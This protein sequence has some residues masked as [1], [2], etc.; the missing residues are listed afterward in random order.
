MKKALIAL[1][2]VA[3]V[4]GIAAVV[5]TFRPPQRPASLEKVARTPARLA[6]GEYLVRHVLACNECHTARDWSR[7]GGPSVGRPGAGG[8]CYNQDHGF[9]GTVCGSN[10]TA[11]RS[12]GI[13]AWTDGEVLRSIREGVDRDG[14]A[15]FP[16]MPYTE[17]R[18][19]SDEDTRAVVAYLRGLPP[20]RH[21]VRET[22]IDFPVSFFIRMAPRPLDGPVL[23]PD[24]SDPVRYGE[25]LA[26]VSGCKFCHTPVD[27]RNQPIEERAFGG[28]QEFRGPW[29][30]VA[31]SNLTPHPTGLGQRSRENFVSLF[32]SFADV[33]TVAVPTRPGKN[34][35]MPWFAYAGMTDF[36]L[37]AIYTYLRTVKPVDSSVEKYPSAAR[38]TQP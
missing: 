36:D 37:G 35:V 2:A 1:V 26:T 8:D 30:I 21:A 22:E 11:D 27:R 32:R 33:S 4:L 14:Q 13:G 38:A 18:H 12:T 16:L 24:P 6:R 7:W 15:L 9:P 5:A 20:V 17:Y 29:G 31:S 34:T 23:E 3:A 19:L 28:G 10:I 25:Y